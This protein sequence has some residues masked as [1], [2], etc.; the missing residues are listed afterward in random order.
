MGVAFEHWKQGK[1]RKSAI[2]HLLWQNANQGNGSKSFGGLPGG[3]GC[4]KWGI[5]VLDRSNRFNAAPSPDPTARPP[6]F[7]SS[8][9]CSCSTRLIIMRALCVERQQELGIAHGHRNFKSPEPRPKTW[10]VLRFSIA[11]SMARYGAYASRDNSCSWPAG[12]RGS[13]GNRGAH[14][15]SS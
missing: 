10:S 14:W 11:G 12:K 8:C 15:G 7:S 1:S 4:K 9:S 6:I 5:G 3:T 2:N 13:R